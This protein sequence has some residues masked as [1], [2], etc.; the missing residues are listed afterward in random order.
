MRLRKNHSFARWQLGR[1]FSV[2]PQA[3]GLV[4]PDAYSKVRNPIFVFG[5]PMLFDFL[6]ALQHRY[7]FLLLDS[8]DSGAGHLLPS[9][10][11][12]A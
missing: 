8:G 3:S 9:G 6:V 10:R 2:T 11:E 12:G 7:A 4:T 1:L 5:R